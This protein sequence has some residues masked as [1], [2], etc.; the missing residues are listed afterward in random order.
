[1][2][3]RLCVRGLVHARV[4]ADRRWFATKVT[5]VCGRSDRVEAARRMMQAVRGTET[6]GRQE[7]PVKQRPSSKEPLAQYGAFVYEKTE[8]VV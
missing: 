8:L 2:A 4:E 3:F 7:T 5:R 1:M 6:G